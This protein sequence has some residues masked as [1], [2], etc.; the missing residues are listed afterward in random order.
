MMR[1][2]KAVFEPRVSL[3]VRGAPLLAYSPN[4]FCGAAIVVT[5]SPAM[6]DKNGRN[7][8]TGDEDVC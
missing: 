5:E 1:G 4:P 6:L 8:P 3:A 2:A 7:A